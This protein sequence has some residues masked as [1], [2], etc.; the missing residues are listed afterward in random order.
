MVAK[1]FLTQAYS[2]KRWT[3]LEKKVY[4]YTANQHVALD[5]SALKLFGPRYLLEDVL[6]SSN[7]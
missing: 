6:Y 2:L 3:R 5:L 7:E 4:M 1:M